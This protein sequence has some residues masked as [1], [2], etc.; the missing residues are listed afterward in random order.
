M[1]SRREMSALTGSRIGSG[2]CQCVGMWQ[3]RL[4]PWVGLGWELCTALLLEAHPPA[5]LRAV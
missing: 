5:V 3:G 4:C 2:R 1:V